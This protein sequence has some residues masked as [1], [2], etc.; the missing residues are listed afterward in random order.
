M[1]STPLALVLSLIGLLFDR[2]KIPALIG[3][4]IGGGV[5]ALFFIKAL[6]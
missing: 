6:C 4:V 3:L 1:A 5:A 2:N